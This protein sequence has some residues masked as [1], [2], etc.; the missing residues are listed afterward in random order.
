MVPPFVAPSKSGSVNV[1]TGAVLSLTVIVWAHVAVLP[2]A[3]VALYVLVNI[4][5]LTQ[6]WL[7]ITSLTQATVGVP[8]LSEAMTAATLTGGTRDAH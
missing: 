1:T 6:V 3:S 8:Q 7:D 5:L 4:Y 2:L